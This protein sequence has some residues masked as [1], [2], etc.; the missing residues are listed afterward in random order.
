MTSE[1]KEERVALENLLAL[2]DEQIGFEDEPDTDKIRRPSNLYIKST[3]MTPL[4]KHRMKVFLDLENQ[5]MS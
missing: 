3:K 4:Y 2:L 1:D 5:C